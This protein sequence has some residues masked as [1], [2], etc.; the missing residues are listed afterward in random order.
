[1]YAHA[2]S[3]LAWSLCLLCLLC[4]VLMAAAGILFSLNN[5]TS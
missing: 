1:M 3:W 2:A 4:L 5:R